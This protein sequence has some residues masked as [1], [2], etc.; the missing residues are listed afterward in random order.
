MVGEVSVEDFEQILPAVPV[1]EL[2]QPAMLEA[3]IDVPENQLQRFKKGQQANIRWYGSDSTHLA[4]LEEISTV[5]HPI[6]QTYDVVFAFNEEAMN[7]LPGK[8]VTIDVSFENDGAREFCVPFSAV[9]QE[10]VESYIYIASKQDKKVARKQVTVERIAEDALCISGE[11]T[12][13]QLIV[14]AGVHFL[15]DGQVVGQLLMNE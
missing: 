12:P 8:S 13:D 9:L 15:N 1:M 14:T 3:V 4:T 7:I 2:H 5:A 11:L 10:G 6:K